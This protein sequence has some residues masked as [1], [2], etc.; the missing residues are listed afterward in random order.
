MGSGACSSKATRMM[1]QPRRKT[2]TSRRQV[3]RR[4]R[5]GRGMRAVTSGTV[6]AGMAS[7]ASPPT[8][9]SHQVATATASHR[10]AARSG[11]VMWVRC[12]CH[13]ARLVILKPCSIQARKPYQQALL[14]SGGKSVRSNHGSL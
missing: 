11:M 6:L 7:S 1:V 8:L 3:A 4:S 2:L 5:S 9:S 12:H 14:A 10:R 13:P